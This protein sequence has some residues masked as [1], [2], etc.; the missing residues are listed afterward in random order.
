MIARQMRKKVTQ[1]AIGRVINRKINIKSSQLIARDVKTGRLLT[2][3][4]GSITLES[5]LSVKI[6]FGS[7]LASFGASLMLLLGKKAK[8]R[9]V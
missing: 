2:L 4:A 3:I 6:F 7:V 8:Q 1:E 9:S 5:S